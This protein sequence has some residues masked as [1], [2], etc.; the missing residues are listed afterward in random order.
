MRLEKNNS[1]SGFLKINFKRIL[2][3]KNLSFLFLVIAVISG[4]IISNKLKTKGYSGLWDFVNVVSS[5][6]FE[7]LKA[8]PEVLSIEIKDKDFKKLE[9]LRQQALERGVIINEQD[10]DYVPAQLFHN[11]EKIDVKLRLKGHMTDHLQNNKWSFRIKTK[12]N[13]RFMG[14]KRFSVQHPGTRGYIYEWI[15]HELMKREDVIA[16]RYK[17]IS[18]K[19]NGNDWG[20]YAVEE[21]FESELVENNHRIK[22]PI[23]RY[24]PDLYW[25]NR[26]N[27]TQR[28][29]SFDEY[30]SYYSANPEAY[31]ENKVLADTLQKKYYMKAI[32]LIEGL[33]NRKVSVE[34]GFDIK[35]LAKF[36]A[37]IDLVG[38]IHSI[39]W[40]DIKYYYNPVTARLEP[41]AYES[42][43][44]L[45]SR[46]ISSAYKFVQIDSLE[47]YTN[48]HE[49]IFSNK[50]FFSEYITQLERMTQPSYFDA[51]FDSSNEELNRN[52]RIIYKE[53]PYKKFDRSLYYKRQ[54]LLKKILDAP[55]A[56]HA[57]VST[58]RNSELEL[59]LAS[60]DAFPVSVTSVSIGNIE[61][62][63]DKEILL[64]AKQAKKFLQYTS[65]RFSLPAGLVINDSLLVNMKINYQLPGSSVKKQAAIFPFPHTDDQ[66]IAEES[67]NKKSNIE[68]FDFL[69]VDEASRTITF[70]EGK[71]VILKTMIIPAAYKLICDNRSRL[72]LRNNAGIISYSPLI[73]KG[74]EDEHLVI[75]SSDSTGQ[76]IQV[77]GASEGSVFEH[78]TF[79]NLPELK[80]DSW[81]RNGHLSFY[82][83]PV[84]FFA[85]DFYKGSASAAVSIIRS[86]YSFKTCYFGQ[87]NNAI[88]ISY[89][90]GTIDNNVFEDCRK[91]AIVLTMAQLKATKNTFNNVKNKCFNLKDGS[92]L[93]AKDIKVRNSYTGVSAN[94]GSDVSIQGLTIENTEFGVI[95]LK[96][97]KGNTNSRIE[98]SSS[99]F[100]NVKMPYIKEKRSELVVDGKAIQEETT[101]IDAIIKK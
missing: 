95:A 35:R 77:I 97:K 101:D 66:Y 75:E 56:L 86:S 93:K 57:Y 52:L 26:Y 32:A 9:K 18:I 47:N 51:F 3:W 55:K 62:R 71:N 10:G 6:Y 44:N 12:G 7:G 46:D 25:V 73:F 68:E 67:K 37:I 41:V 69:H 48:W 22:A 98:I 85:C 29:S 34:D 88:D 1:R 60:I 78:V 81:K 43:T 83:S 58:T 87:V 99:S 90:E 28:Q 84:S 45:G 33:R 24:N 36:H 15:Y 59:Q 2:T 63:P 39:D 65:H 50:A 96:N 21:N 38:G 23:L 100:I 82:E 49:M 80:N 61:I 14:M 31:R 40:S 70:R 20:V 13:D 19:V 54:A 74:S 8:E 92:Q 27:M 4:Y 11:G 76:G 94:D 17:F 79:L 5:N 16:L 91:N 42:F 72:D 30:A 64:P 53:F 89:S